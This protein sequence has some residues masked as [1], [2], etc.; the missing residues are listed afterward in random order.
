[1]DCNISH[2]RIVK[3]NGGEKKLRK[4]WTV[5][6]AAFLIFMLML[7]GSAMA[8]S[9]LQNDPAKAKIEALE[10]RGIVSGVNDGRFDP[11][12]LVTYAQ[13]VQMIVK[14]L[15][16][17]LD[18]IHFVKKP[19]A[20]DYF[21]RIQNDAWYAKAF[22]IAYHNGLPIPENVDPQSA[23]NKET[24]C[25]LLGHALMSKGDFP[26]IEI[27][28][29]IAD[30]DEITKEY[31][32]SIQTLLILNIAKLDS[33]NR[34]SPKAEITRSQAAEMVYNAIGFLRK[35]EKSGGQP[36]PDVSLTVDKVNDQI[37]RVTLSWGEKPNSCYRISI[38]R[39]DFAPDQKAIVYYRLHFPQEG[40]LCGQ[41]ITRPT[42]SAYIDSSYQATI[43]P[44]P[45]ISVPRPFPSSDVVPLPNKGN[46]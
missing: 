16:L 7:C 22:I 25:N 35:Q 3:D 18:N 27:Y 30:E 36:D 15:D 12:G 38:P 1:M 43:R 32:S 10:R 4:K 17:N 9:D 46:E 40:T 34:F 41:V 23:M 19:E 8:F 11:K 5:S 39:I 24:F 26:M 28:K 42:A 45:K 37:N 20:G 44:L 33:G 13:G 29:L 14:G 6:V 21:T 31:M 2:F